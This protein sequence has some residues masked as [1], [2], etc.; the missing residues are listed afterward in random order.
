MLVVVVTDWRWQRIPNVVTFPTMAL[1][2]LLGLGEAIGREGGLEPAALGAPLQG[3]FL[4]HLT[5]LAIGLGISYPFYVG[6][7]IKAGDA[8][9]FELGKAKPE[10][11]VWLIVKIERR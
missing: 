8:V 7:G 6:G 11:W 3:G 2:L 5:G 9:R 4:D 1:G 10:D